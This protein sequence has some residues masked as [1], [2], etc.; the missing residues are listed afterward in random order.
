MEELRGLWQR[1]REAPVADCISDGFLRQVARSGII[2]PK[3]IVLWYVLDAWLTPVP[4]LLQQ[5]CVMAW[6]LVSSSFRVLLV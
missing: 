1:W 6:L 2:G 5:T 4:C 3:T